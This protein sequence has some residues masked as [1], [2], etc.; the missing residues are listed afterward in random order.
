[1]MA[2]ERATPDSGGSPSDAASSAE[3]LASLSELT[4]PELRTE[5]RRLYRSQAPRLSRELMVRALAYRIQERACGGLAPALSRRLREYGR[6]DAK[7]P[8]GLNNVGTLPKPGTRLV[9]EWNGRTYTVMITED[10]FAYNGMT[11][12]S[13]TK[14]AGIITGAHWSGPRFFGIGGKSLK[15]SNAGDDGEGD[16]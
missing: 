16:A 4:L 3:R 14:I 1:M 8:D 13:L 12:G 10:G 7:M 11:Y 2:P 15:A 5:W 9:R 6:K